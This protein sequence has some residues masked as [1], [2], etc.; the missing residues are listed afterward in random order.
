[1]TKQKKAIPVEVTNKC[2]IVSNKFRYTFIRTLVD[3]RTKHINLS[4]VEL[5]T[6]N[7]WETDL[8]NDQMSSNQNNGVSILPLSRLYCLISSISDGEHGSYE[9]Y[10][11]T[12]I[13]KDNE[14]VLEIIVVDYVES[15]KSKS[16]DDPLYTIN[17]N[18]VHPIIE[19]QIVQLNKQIEDTKSLAKMSDL[20]KQYI[21]ENKK[22]L[23]H[24]LKENIHSKETI[25]QLESKMMN[26]T[27]SG[28]LMYRDFVNKN[29]TALELGGDIIILEQKINVLQTYNDLIKKELN[30]KIN[31]SEDLQSF[32]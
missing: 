28:E 7:K 11:P 32:C 14:E 10:L 26:M 1:M 24:L 8:T 9:L 16:N 15:N 17:L 12:Y 20:F 25:A 6:L 4:I 21:L 27:L 30:N 23:D 13:P 22:T 19:S 29:N 31:T 5:K 2:E 18:R 3:S